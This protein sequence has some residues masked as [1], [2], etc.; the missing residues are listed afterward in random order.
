MNVTVLTCLILTFPFF[1]PTLDHESGAEEGLRLHLAFVVIS[2]CFLLTQEAFSIQLLQC[3]TII[4]GILNL[5]CYTEYLNCYTSFFNTA[6]HSGLLSF[7]VFN[8][9]N[10]LVSYEEPIP[11]FFR[12]HCSFCILD[13]PLYFRSNHCFSFTLHTEHLQPHFS[14]SKFTTPFFIV[15]SAH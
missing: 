4:S 11:L 1:H 8:L 9:Y 13:I 6:S 7:F 5:V 15:L 14:S 10:C 12:M 3:N 2:I